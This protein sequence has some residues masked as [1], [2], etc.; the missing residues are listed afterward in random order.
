MGKCRSW[1]AAGGVLLQIWS[2]LVGSSVVEAASKGSH[3]MSLLLAA[4]DACPRGEG[5][6]GEGKAVEGVEGKGAVGI[7]SMP[8][9][10]VSAGGHQQRMVPGA[11]SMEL[12]EG[13]GEVAKDSSL[14]LLGSAGG[15]QRILAPVEV[16]RALE[17]AAGL[18]EVEVGVKVGVVGGWVAEAGK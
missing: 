5:E 15:H 17:V 12:E 1:S 16:G 6:A 13:V 11:G 8:A 7:H 3:S 4:V 18:V 2:S 14:G 10:L 9:R